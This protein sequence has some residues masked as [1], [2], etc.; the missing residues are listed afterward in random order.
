MATEGTM[1]FC[2]GLNPHRD[3]RLDSLASEVWVSFEDEQNNEGTGVL[4]FAVETQART[5]S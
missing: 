4:V 2:C 1:G 5:A 3:N